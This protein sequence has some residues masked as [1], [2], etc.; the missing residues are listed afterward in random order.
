MNSDLWCG[1]EHNESN[2]EVQFPALGMRR[3]AVR[4]DAERLRCKRSWRGHRDHSQPKSWGRRIRKVEKRQR[5]A[6]R[7]H[8]PWARLL[9]S[10]L[11]QLW[12]CSGPWAYPVS[13]NGLNQSLCS[14]QQKALTR[15]D[16]SSAE[17]GV[18]PGGSLVAPTNRFLA[19]PARQACLDLPAEQDVSS[20]RHLSTVPG[21]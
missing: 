20:L 9:I 10:E 2:N 8:R 18:A 21:A 11:P 13:Y 12:Q 4:G 7:P 17:D 16:F 14:L 1:L 6:L 5:D 3:L 15:S 19:S